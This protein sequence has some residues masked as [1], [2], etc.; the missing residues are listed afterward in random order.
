MGQKR[1]K[2]RMQQQRSTRMRETILRERLP[3][4]CKS[5]VEED[6]SF[7]GLEHGGCSSTSLNTVCFGGGLPKL[8]NYKNPGLKRR[9]FHG[10]ARPE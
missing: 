7:T 10:S 4:E 2:R 8:S 1:N 9:T 6:Q 5:E 3:C